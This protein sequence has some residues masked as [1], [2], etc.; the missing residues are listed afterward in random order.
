M[1]DPKWQQMVSATQECMRYR[2]KFILLNFPY[3]CIVRQY[4]R[5]P[6]LRVSFKLR[7][8]LSSKQYYYYYFYLLR[9][10]AL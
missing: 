6:I 5:L 1:E 10:S 7:L 9:I 4:S 3:S 8:F 2:D